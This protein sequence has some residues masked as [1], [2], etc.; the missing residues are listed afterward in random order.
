MK[1]IKIKSIK[2]NYRVA[3]KLY[4][5][6][7]ANIVEQF[8]IYLNSLLPDEIDEIKIDF[9]INENGLLSVRDTQSVVELFDSFT[10]FYYINDRLPYTE[11]HLFVP[12]GKTLPGI[13]GKKLSLK[14]LFTKF[15]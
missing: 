8:R 15:F 4:A 5:S 1:K 14:E 10:M 2:H 11:D 12:D 7:Y 9:R 3:R 6:T 13:V